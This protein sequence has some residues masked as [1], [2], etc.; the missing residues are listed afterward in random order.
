MARH[1]IDLVICCHHTRRARFHGLLH[2][3]QMNFAQLALADARCTGVYAAGRF[4]LCAEV[5]RNDLQTGARTALH[6]RSS[7]LT[8]EIRI[9]AVALFASA[10]ARV[11]QNV[12]HGNERKIH[13]HFF[14]LLANDLKTLF[15]ELRVPRRAHAEVH[16]QQIAVERL[17]AVRALAAHQHRNAEAGVLQHIALRQIIGADCVHAGQARCIILV[18]PRICTV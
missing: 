15:N 10:P 16:R 3:G 12:Q 4:A 7:V 2:R 1:T 6:R 17:V 8:A 9:F 13:A 5:L 18:R 14:L 11:T